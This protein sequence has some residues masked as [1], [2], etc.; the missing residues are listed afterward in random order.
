MDHLQ[1]NMRSR[2]IHVINSERWCDPRAKLL[3][4]EAWE[5]HKIPVCR[6]LKVVSEGQLRPLNVTEKLELT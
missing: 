2:D 4:G 1:A 5:Q 3:K 6:S